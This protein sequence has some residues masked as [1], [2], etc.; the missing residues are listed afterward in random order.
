MALSL[1]ALI[2]LLWLPGGPQKPMQTKPPE[3]WWLSDGYGILVRSDS[4]GLH[5]YELTSISCIPSG[6]A[7]QVAIQAS[8]SAYVFMSKHV[9]IRIMRTDDPNILRM[10][11]DGAASDIVLRRTSK[12][13]ESCRNKEPNT[14]QE[15]YAIFWETFAE[16]YPFFPLHKLDWR[17]ADKRM[18]PEISS[19]TKPTELFQI[20]RQMIEPLQDSHTGLEAPEI[21]AEFDGWRNDPNHL[22]ENDWKKAGLIIE[23]RYA[24]GGLQAYCK[25]HIQFGIV[26]ND[27]GYL[28]VT[29]FYDYADVEGYAAERQCLLRSLDTI[30][31]GTQKWKGMVIDVRLNHGGDDPLGIEIA[32]RLTEKKYLA[33]FKVARNNTELDA[34]LHFTNRQPSWVVP[35]ARPKF[36]GKVVLLIGPDTVSAGET[37][38]M[39][40]LGR[41]PRVTMIGLNTQGVFSDI[42]SR[43]LPNGWYFH[44]PNEVYLTA[45]GRAF[46]ATGVPP[47]VRV[48]FFIGAD[49]Q[50]GHDLALEEAIQ[51]LT[52]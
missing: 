41:E 48:P 17:A 28:R 40:L 46:D 36:G 31:G 25:S 10:Y 30:F 51:Q 3:G 35:S 42:L 26:G 20:V 39:A 18:R 19:G 47:D 34:S 50:N 45:D 22:D 44:L 15:N 4:S 43:S 9:T 24:H 32:A 52:K 2:W 7:T 8:E 27:V 13:P 16:Q 5:T 38:A 14:P 6:S 11:T 37:F 23:A 29:T 1:A 21:K 49:L 33:Y 12:P